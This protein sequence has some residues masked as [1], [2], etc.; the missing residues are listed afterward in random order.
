MVAKQPEDRAAGRSS[1]LDAC[2]ESRG[3]LPRG[4]GVARRV[5][6]LAAVDGRIVSAGVLD[7][8]T[9][10]RLGDRSPWAETPLTRGSPRS[11]S[12]AFGARRA[13]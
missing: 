2:C 13:V 7:R 1:A 4:R 5:R 8:C 6:A 10:L 9:G 3:G 12:P 11:W